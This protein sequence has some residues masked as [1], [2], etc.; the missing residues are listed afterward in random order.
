MFELPG[1]MKPVCGI[2]REEHAAGEAVV[3]RHD[4][5]Q[6]RQRLLAAVLVIAGEKDDVLAGAGALVA[7]ID[8]QVWI[9]R[10]GGDQQRQRPPS[11]SFE[12]Q[13]TIGRSGATEAP[14]VRQ[15]FTCL[16]G[17]TASVRSVRTRSGSRPA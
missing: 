8:D 17:L 14:G 5:R 13:A 16:A 2:G 3:P 4:P 12:G 11:G 1:S 10:A 6:R 15:S 7:L 9:L